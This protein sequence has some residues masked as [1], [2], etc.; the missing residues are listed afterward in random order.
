MAAVVVLPWVPLTQI[1]LQ[2]EESA[3]NTRPRRKIFLG[4][5]GCL[6]LGITFRQR[7]ASDNPVCLGDAE[8]ARTIPGCRVS[9]AMGR[10]GWV[11]VAAAYFKTQLLQN[12][13]QP[14]LANPEEMNARFFSERNSRIAAISAAMSLGADMLD[15]F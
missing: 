6:E 4:L 15:A 1:E 5:A 8:H 14:D 10:D 7:A 9:A 12:E 11:Q 3:A 13:S 2:E